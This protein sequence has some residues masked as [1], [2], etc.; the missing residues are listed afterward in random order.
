MAAGD[1]AEAARLQFLLRFGFLVDDLVGCAAGAIPSRVRFAITCVY[2][3]SF[4]QRCITALVFGVFHFHWASVAQLG[5]LMTL[6][7][8]FILYLL[9]V[10]PYCSLLLLVSEVIAYGCEVVIL[11][12]AA[13]ALQHPYNPSITQAFLI[14]YYLDIG[15]VLLPDLLHLCRL[16]FE[17]CR[18]RSCAHS[19]SPQSCNHDSTAKPGVELERK[20]DA[21]ATAAASAALRLTSNGQQ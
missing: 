17:W 1:P 2:L 11:A 14:C 8:A 19:E 3:A 5:L 16:A 13:L 21:A 20:A 12:L 15:A 7:L 4:L 6:H 10:R 18:G 9:A